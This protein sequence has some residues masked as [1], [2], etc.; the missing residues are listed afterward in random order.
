MVQ[1]LTSPEKLA[2][3][4][5]NPVASQISPWLIEV[6]YPVGCHGLLPLYFG[7][8]AVVGRENI[9]LQGP[10]IVAPTHRSRWD[11]LLVP[12]AVGR[13]ASSR[14]LRFM[15]TASEM[16]GLQG[17]FIRRLGGFPVDIERPALNSLAHSVEVLCAGEMLVIFP[18]GGIFRDNC[19]HPLKR[20][21]AR[22]ALAVEAQQPGSGIKILPIGLQYSQPYPTWGTDVTVKIGSPLTVAS[23]A[24]NSLKQSS[25]RLTAALAAALRGLSSS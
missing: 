19:L 13:L 7:R 6:V 2:A 3:Q 14:D 8:L 22:I 21:V 15:V 16:R 25:E 5:P 23:Y 24:S 12:H 1:I 11:A 18:E 9:P 10:V 17:W 20:G 4:L